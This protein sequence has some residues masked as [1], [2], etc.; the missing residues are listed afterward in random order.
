VNIKAEALMADI[1]AGK[2]DGLEG[3]AA[4]TVQNKP[5]TILNAA[6]YKAVTPE[7]FAIRAGNR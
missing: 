6:S 1:V 3:E 4:F 5:G 2:V 7:G